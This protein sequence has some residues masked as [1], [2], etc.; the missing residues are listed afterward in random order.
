MHTTALPSSRS[1]ETWILLSPRNAPRP[2]SAQ[3]SSPDAGAKT[4]SE[5]ALVAMTGVLAALRG[6]APGD[7]A[8]E[9]DDAAASSSPHPNRVLGAQAAGT[10]IN[11]VCGMAVST[12]TPMHVETYEG[13]KYY[14]CCDGCLATFRQNPAK[15][16]AVHRSSASRASP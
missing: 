5:I 2:L 11:P 14:F 10:F 16:A 1:L 12:V 15:Y 4:P 6:R 9:A 7:E 13:E 3:K 8:R